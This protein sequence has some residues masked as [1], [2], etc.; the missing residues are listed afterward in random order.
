MEPRW[1]ERRQ[2]ILRVH[3]H[4]PGQSFASGRRTDI[5]EEGNALAP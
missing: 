4:T 2:I 1:G 5:N 3:R